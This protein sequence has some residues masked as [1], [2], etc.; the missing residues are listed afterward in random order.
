MTTKKQAAQA[1]GAV[2][3]LVAEAGAVDSARDAPALEPFDWR[4]HTELKHEEDRNAVAEYLS[5]N[6]DVI[7]FLAMMRESVARHYEPAPIVL[8]WYGH[9]PGGAA[10]WE[11]MPDLWAQVI[12]KSDKLVSDG[13]WFGHVWADVLAARSRQPLL[14]DKIEVAP[15]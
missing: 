4:K 9:K 11:G 12:T 8:R 6:P 5:K 14:A 10:V 13:G 1:R 7:A 15:W 3:G 2:D